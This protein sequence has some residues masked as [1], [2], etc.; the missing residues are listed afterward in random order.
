MENKSQSICALETE[1]LKLDENFEFFDKF[2]NNSTQEF[3]I[4]DL[5]SFVS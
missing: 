5:E 1:H 4:S 3:S 2:I